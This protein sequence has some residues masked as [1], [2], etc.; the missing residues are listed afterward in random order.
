MPDRCPRC[1]RK[2]DRIAIWAPVKI[3]DDDPVHVCMTCFKEAKHID[4]V[5]AEACARAK[6]KWLHD[7]SVKGTAIV[8]GTA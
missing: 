3:G 1:N 7:T 8:V 2:M 6:R 5:F 4:K